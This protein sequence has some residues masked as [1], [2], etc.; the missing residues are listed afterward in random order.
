MK[1]LYL[2]DIVGK[3][4][5]SAV[6]NSLDHLKQK[7]K[8]DIT[9]VNC[10][11]ASHGFGITP[12]AYKSLIEAGVDAMVSGNHI[13]DQKDIVPILNEDRRIVRPLNYPEN[14]PGFGFYEAQLA[15]GRKILITQVLGRVFM[16]SLEPPIVA[17]DRLLKNY[18][19]G[20]NISAIFVDVHAE[21]TSEKQ[22]IGHYLDSRVSVVTGTHTHVPTAD[23]KILPKGTAYI[24]DVGMCGNHDGVLGFEK[25]E[26]INRLGPTFSKN[27]L[28]PCT[29]DGKINGV[30]VET[31]DNTG[32]AIS[33][34]QILQ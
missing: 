13:W 27:P 32:L 22:A 3:A 5:R 24:T 15:D 9:I 16:E 25:E 33:I 20:A 10:E 23:A 12:K 2:G 28:I 11:N 18:I 19:M 26:P 29:K 34:E 8:P 7:Y 17:L 6:I 21:A 30:F 1:I 4:G 31:D 14:T